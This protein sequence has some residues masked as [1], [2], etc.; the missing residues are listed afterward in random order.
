MKKQTIERI[1]KRIR[2]TKNRDDKVKA[3]LLL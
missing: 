2:L 3:K 1:F